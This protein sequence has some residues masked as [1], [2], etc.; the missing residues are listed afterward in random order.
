MGVD[1]QRA[2]F[3]NHRAH[4]DGAPRLAGELTVA[5][6]WLSDDDTRLENVTTL[7][8]AEGIGG[9]AIQARDG[10][11]LVTSSIP[12]GVGIESSLWPQ[13]QQLTSLMGKVLRINTDGSVFV[14]QDRGGPKQLGD[15]QD[16]FIKR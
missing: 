11:L 16:L 14:L 5:R 2:A 4:G 13:P 9:R 12:A 15:A 6:A 7:L 10:T 8:R 1:R 3:R